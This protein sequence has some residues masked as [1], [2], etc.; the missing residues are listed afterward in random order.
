[1]Q[2]LMQYQRVLQMVQSYGFD[3]IQV[4]N[5]QVYR[6]AEDGVEKPYSIFDLDKIHVSFTVTSNLD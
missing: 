1:V 5:V 4:I 6:L 2:A 3:S